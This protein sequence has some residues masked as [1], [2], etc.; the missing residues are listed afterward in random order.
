MEHARLRPLLVW[1]TAAATSISLVSFSLLTLFRRLSQTEKILLTGISMLGRFTCVFAICCCVIASPGFGEDLNWPQWRG[2]NGTGKTSAVDVVTHWGPEQNV[3]WRFD[4]PEAGNSTPVVWGDYVFLAQPLSE[5]NERAL[6]CVDRRAGREQWRRSVVYDQ[7][8]ATH[9]TNP[10]CSA[11]PA[12]D[13]QRVVAWFGS[14]GLVCWDLDGNELW[15]RDLGRQ[16]HMWGYGSSP[17]LF[18]GLCILNFGPGNREFL[19]AVDAST[20]ETRWQVDSMDDQSE[21]ELS[22][23]QNDGN[24]KDFTSNKERSERLRGSWNTPITVRVNGHA[25]LI[26]ALP[27]RVSALDPYTGERLWTCGDGAPLAYA[28]LMEENGV[29][30]ALGGYRGASFAVR[31]GGRGDVTA[32]HRLWHKPED[33]GW[34]G[35]GVIHES[36]VYICDTGGVIYCIDVEMGDLLWKSRSD[37]GGTWSSI[38]QTADG[39]MYLLTKSGTTTVFRPDRE[40]LKRVATNELNEASNASVIV[41]GS[42]V[43]VRTDQALWC[44]ANPEQN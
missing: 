4:L 19:I 35:T 37:G 31:A 36:T 21:R 13:G 26:V 39:T 24:A 10:Y 43:L 25:E 8:E 20:G 28:S 23:P 29:V 9:R 44:F 18:D 15:R 40:A 22:G 5:S 42:D 38:T 1:I 12:T 30:V 41:A 7:Q 34:L 17:I 3:K 6:I 16:E 33:I 27:R 2:P 32:T 11:S 14:A